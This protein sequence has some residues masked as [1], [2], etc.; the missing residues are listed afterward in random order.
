MD[1]RKRNPADFALW[2]AHKPGEPAWDSPWGKGRPGWHIEDTAITIT[3]FGPQYDMHGGA[4]ELMFPHHEA[5]IA[6]AE[7]YTGVSPF[8]K[9]WMHGGL[10]NVEGE[11]MAKSLGNFWTVKDALKAYV[12]EVVRFFLLYAHYR[13]PV[14]FTREALDEAKASYGRLR[15]TV[16]RLRQ[17]ATAETGVA[18]EDELW[19]AA[20]AA[21]EGF[22]E[23]MDDDFNTREA[24]AALFTL[25]TEVNKALTAGDAAP[26]SLAHAAAFFDESGAILGLWRPA[27]GVSREEI[28]PLVEMLIEQRE[29]ARKAKDFETADRI[30]DELSKWGV[31]LE[32]SATGPQWRLK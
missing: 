30:R 20:D 8:V 7:A 21:R 19:K 24:L 9:Y 26:E 12:P 25:A 13:K 11:K 28:G 22:H 14:D 32:D 4:T 16:D 10:L 23:A 27:A 15:E 18:P 2:K 3:H 1:E 29:T 31:L 5:E 17:A 6:Q